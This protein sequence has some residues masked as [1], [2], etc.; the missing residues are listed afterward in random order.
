MP[1]DGRTDGHDVVSSRLSQLFENEYKMSQPFIVPKKRTKNEVTSE[2][3]GASTK[4]NVM[5]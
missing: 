2:P 4:A 1:T 3:H 5:K